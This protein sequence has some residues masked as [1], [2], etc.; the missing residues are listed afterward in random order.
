MAEVR[1][2]TDGW[3]LA[4]RWI[5][6]M[7]A[8]IAAGLFVWFVAEAGARVFPDLAW[9]DPQGIPLLIVIVAAI[10]GVL[11]AWRWELAGGLATVVGAAAIVGLVVWGSGVDMVYGALWF[12]S[13]LLVAGLLYLG[14]CARTGTATVSDPEA[15]EE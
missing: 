15:R 13:P 2:R 1:G 11:A 7:L 4:M 6:R 10:G 14:C 5:A 9:R 12:A 8:L 3:T